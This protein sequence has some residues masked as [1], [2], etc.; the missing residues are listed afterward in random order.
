MNDTH[1]Q[2]VTVDHLTRTIGAFLELLADRCV[3]RWVDAR[4]LLLRSRY[5]QQFNEDAL[6]ISLATADTG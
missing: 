3:I 6:P 2:V 5:N 1:C 4:T